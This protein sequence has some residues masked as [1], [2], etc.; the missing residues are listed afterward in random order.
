M[1]NFSFGGRN[2]KHINGHLLVL[3]KIH[4]LRELH[5]ILVCRRYGG[6]RSGKAMRVNESVDVAFVF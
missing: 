4:A 5:R 6:V 2:S 3:E 1:W